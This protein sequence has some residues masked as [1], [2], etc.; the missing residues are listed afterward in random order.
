MGKQFCSGGSS[1]VMGGAVLFG[2]VV[3]LW[4]EQFC[5]GE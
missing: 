4:G 3:L 2:G 5:S 1:L